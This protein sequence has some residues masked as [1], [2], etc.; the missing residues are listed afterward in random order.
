M[1][2]KIRFEKNSKNNVLTVLE[3][4]EVD[5]GIV[6]PLHEEDYALD[7]MVKAS[8]EGMRPFIRLLR[9][10][11]FF[12]TS[13]L[14]AKLY[15]ETLDFFKTEDVANITIEYDDV[16]SFP[17]EEEFFLEDEDVELDKIL[18]EDGTTV[19]DEMKE[20]DVD[21]DTISFTPEDISEHE[22]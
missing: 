11:T 16:E 18:E 12:P 22:N 8:S 5:P 15:E 3:S 10:R 14:C 6:M 19:E 4:S 1:R 13:D 2:Q 9:R 21:D 20:I 17:G 7:Q